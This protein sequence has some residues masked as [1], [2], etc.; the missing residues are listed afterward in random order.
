[1]RVAV[2]ATGAQGRQAGLD[3]AAAGGN[4][5]DAAIAAMLTALATEPGIVSLGG[6]GYVCVWPAGG[7]PVVIDGNVEMPGRGVDPA[8]L[9]G[10]VREVVTRYGGGVTMH[11]GWGSVGTPGAVAALGAAHAAYA[12]RPWA[13]LVR[14]AAVAVR[15]GYP[16]SHAAARYLDI[17]A[18]DLFGQDAEAFALITRPDGSPIRGGEP[19][20][21]LLLADTLDELA[22]EGPDLFRTGRVAQAL[23]A[24]M[25]EADGLVSAQDLAGYRAVTRPAHRLDAGGWQIA[26]NPPPAIGGVM[27]AVLLGE[28]AQRAPWTWAD[29]LQVQREVLG[30]RR[31]VHDHSADLEADGIDLLARFGRDGLA[32]L[33]SA[34]RRGAPSTA[35]VSAVDEAGNACAI[36]LSSGYGA[37][38]CIPGTGILL[39]NCLGELE[40]NRRGLHALEPG[41]RLA[42]NMAPTC[43]RSDD[44][45][46][47]AI[48]SPGADRITT[49]LMQVLGLT[50]L[51][52][53]G[54]TDA[55]EHPRLH[56]RIADHPGDDAPAAG[57][58]AGDGAADV[59]EYER[60]EQIA[61]A[62]EASGL[63]GN[64]YPEPHMYFGGVGAAQLGPDGRLEAAGDPRREAATGVSP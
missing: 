40:L 5:V 37:G 30:Y 56:V 11:A 63:R 46:V 61:A 29:V 8:R 44:G 28:L 54:L 52:G 20:R 59:V 50:C 25:A 10:G 31:R 14:P 42:S 32:A 26:T 15:D 19:C 55:V 43:G 62:V 3:V 45:R 58:D 23:A 18:Q 33:R 51:S 38:M 12:Q 53:L 22:D 7:D 21:N 57:A 36:T 64:E 16:M 39:N 1:M 60:D 4:A 35:N 41:T 6:G 48:G 34:P 17:T 49:A 13:D 2:A 9:G 27:L 24:A 47:L